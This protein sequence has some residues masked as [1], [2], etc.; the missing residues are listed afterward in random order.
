M[1][2]EGLRTTHRNSGPRPPTP[3]SVR[4][5]SLMGGGGTYWP[6]NVLIGPVGV[7]APRVNL[8]SGEVLLTW[9]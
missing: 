4:G 2:I 9:I 8:I 1:E 5:M 6:G 7:G 3:S